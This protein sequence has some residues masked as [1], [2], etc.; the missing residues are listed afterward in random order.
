M[1]AQRSDGGCGGLPTARVAPAAASAGSARRHE[2]TAGAQGAGGRKCLRC[3]QAS[4]RAPPTRHPITRACRAQVGTG[5]VNTRLHQLRQPALNYDGSL[6]LNG[7]S[8]VAA[9]HAGQR[10]P[11]TGDCHPGFLDRHNGVYITKTP[12]TRTPF[13]PDA[14]PSAQDAGSPDSP[15][16]RPMVPPL[17]LDSSLVK[18]PRGA[19]LGPELSLRRSA[20]R[21][22]Q[23][24][25][26]TPRAASPTDGD[27]AAAGTALAPHLSPRRGG[28]PVGM[29]S[30]T[31][32]FSAL[33]S[34]NE[35][36]ERGHVDRGDFLERAF[37]PAH[38]HS[39]Y[40]ARIPADFEAFAG[41]LDRWAAGAGGGVEGM[42]GHMEGSWRDVH[43]PD[44]RPF[45]A[46]PKTSLEMTLRTLPQSLTVTDISTQQLN[47]G[48]TRARPLTARDRY[49]VPTGN[50]PR[51]YALRPH[52]ARESTSRPSTRDEQRSAS[53][54]ATGRIQPQVAR[55]LNDFAYV[56]AQPTKGPPSKEA[57]L[58]ASLSGGSSTRTRRA[59]EVMRQAQ[60]QQRSRLSLGEGDAPDGLDIQGEKAVIGERDKWVSP[61]KPPRRE[62][63]GGDKENERGQAVFHDEKGSDASYRVG[64]A[65]E[66]DQSPPSTPRSPRQGEG[67]SP[68]KRAFRGN[69]GPGQQRGRP[70]TAQIYRAQA[71]AHERELVERQ[72]AKAKHD[73]LNKVSD[74]IAL[75]SGRSKRPTTAP[76]RSQLIKNELHSKME[77]RNSHARRTF[78]VMEN[79]HDGVINAQDMAVGLDILNIPATSAE[80]EQLLSEYS[81]TGRSGKHGMNFA[82]YAR[83]L[84]RIRFPSQ[85]PFEGKEV[86]IP[87]WKP[88]ERY[89]S[90]WGGEYGK[91]PEAG[92]ERIRT[93]LKWRIPIPPQQDI[94]VRK[95]PTPRG[96]V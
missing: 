61:R 44:S 5:S 88:S 29:L 54:E 34:F 52:T 46:P 4:L 27:E 15:A 2:G 92:G 67:G 65:A 50:T 17:R 87:L 32:S 7:V 38:P 40:A 16:S 9:P 85:N 21:R 74:D 48:A 30:K 90:K 60:A 6:S 47:C 49:P 95:P 42:R 11:V 68:R 91:G 25:G 82:E 24:A 18:T 86:K 75:F 78:R 80:I 35:T 12:R 36:L 93:K 84:K 22:P 71:D 59:L 66:T 57:S 45:P 43:A 77:V 14:D 72:K 55:G 79:D 70:R 19:G 89:T 3:V 13:S 64:D 83:D 51:Q 20:G 10:N 23:T 41:S 94:P 58:T 8:I 37:V 26:G 76:T 81:G 39:Q 31:G 73:F 53:G 28:V 33:K 62:S 63:F 96:C 1:G 69:A 56:I